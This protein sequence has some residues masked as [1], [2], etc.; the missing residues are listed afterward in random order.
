MIHL[1][2]EATGANCVPA[3]FQT[4]MLYQ[5]AYNVQYLSDEALSHVSKLKCHTVL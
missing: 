2:S 5:R 4:Q 3:T 1:R